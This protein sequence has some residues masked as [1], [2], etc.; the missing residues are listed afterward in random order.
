MSSKHPK[1]QTITVKL[2]TDKPVCKT[3][4]VEAAVT[5]GP[6]IAV[7]CTQPLNIIKLNIKKIIFFIY[8]NHL[9]VVLLNIHIQLKRDE[10]LI[11]CHFDQ[12]YYKNE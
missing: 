3:F 11:P 12:F 8:T 4:P 10:V 9:R 7:D 2:I 1:I 5:T 6:S